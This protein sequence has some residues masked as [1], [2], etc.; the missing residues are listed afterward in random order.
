MTPIDAAELSAFLD[1]ELPTKRAD[2]VRAALSLDP[3]LRQSYERLVSLDADWKE[4]AE[5]AM[6][7]PRVQFAAAPVAGRFRIPAVAIGLLL[8]R[9]AVKALPSLYGASLDAI[10]LALVVGWGLTRIM[11]LTD[12]DRRR[13]VLVPNY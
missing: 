9:I 8:I 11:H 7:Q 10:F 1:G 4:R 12:A 2:E 13:P 6:F 5:T 3:V